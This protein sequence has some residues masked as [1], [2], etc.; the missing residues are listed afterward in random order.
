MSHLTVQGVHHGRH[1]EGAA[2]RREG[3]ARAGTG[4]AGAREGTRD[5]TAGAGRAP[6][7]VSQ[8]TRKTRTGT[9]TDRVS[10]NKEAR[11]TRA[12]AGT[13]RVTLSEEAREKPGPTSSVGQTLRSSWAAELNGRSED[14]TRGTDQARSSRTRGTGWETV[15]GENPT[16]LDRD[17]AALDDMGAE[18]ERQRGQTLKV[19]SGERD[20]RKTAGVLAGKSSEE[21]EELYRGQKNWPAYRDGLDRVRSD[22]PQNPGESDSDYRQRLARAY[23]PY[24]AEQMRKGNYISNHQEGNSVDVSTRDMSRDDVAALN[25]IARERGYPVKYE[26]DH[27]HIDLHRGQVETDPN[28]VTHKREAESR[29][30]RNTEVER[31]VGQPQSWWEWWYEQGDPARVSSW[32]ASEQPRVPSNIA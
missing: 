14:A 6:V 22:H 15:R 7:P 1:P 4:Q 30:D 9:G 21:L 29:I 32:P 10:L 23:E 16:L 17:Q 19:T 12:G 13:D 28:P 25:R 11:E 26:G 18:Y 24:V 5:A 2:S 20:S 8:E 31:G 27:L 3:T